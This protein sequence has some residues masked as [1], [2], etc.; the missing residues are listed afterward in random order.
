[1][2]E[3]TPREVRKVD[4]AK[5]SSNLDHRSLLTPVLRDSDVGNGVSFDSGG[6]SCGGSWKVPARGPLALGQHSGIHQ[7]TEYTVAGD[8]VDAEPPLCRRQRQREG[9]VVEKVGLDSHDKTFDSVTCRG[10]HVILQ[11]IVQRRFA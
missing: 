2:I 7:G 10:H 1:V 8:F 11:G 5:D 9:R 3:R 6:L 4:W